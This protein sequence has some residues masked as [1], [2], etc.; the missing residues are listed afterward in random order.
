MDTGGS[1][2]ILQEHMPLLQEML[3]TPPP[4]VKQEK[5]KKQPLGNNAQHHAQTLIFCPC[6]YGQ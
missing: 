2:K 6:L 3:A 5:I 1:S 4:A